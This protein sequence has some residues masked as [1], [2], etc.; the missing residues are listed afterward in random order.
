M[1]TKTLNKIKKELKNIL[2]G[3][4]LIVFI[5]MMRRHTP[6]DFICREDIKKWTSFDN[7]KSIKI[8][9][10]L[11]EIGILKEYFQSFCHNC[12]WQPEEIYEKEEEIPLYGELICGGCNIKLFFYE[13]IYL[14]KAGGGK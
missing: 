1:K 8:V 12:G 6:G 11:T 2:S 9:D 7:E 14:I 3:L 13:D 10:K 4:E 5:E